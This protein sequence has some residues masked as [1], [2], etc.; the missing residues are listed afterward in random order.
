MGTTA[1]KLAKLVQ[2]KTEI[3][4]AIINKG[5][6]IPDSAT[7]ASYA[8]YIG[9]IQGGTSPTGNIEISQQTGTDVSNYKTASVVSG[10]ASIST[11]SLIINPNISISNTGLITANYSEN[12]SVTTSITTPGWISNDITDNITL[13]GSST[14]QLDTIASNV[15]IPNTVDQII[16]SGQYI[17]GDQ[18]ISGDVN[19]ISD[20]IRSTVSIFGVQ[21]GLV[22]NKYYT[23]ETTPSDDLGIDGDI[24]IQY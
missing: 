24:Y 14:K 17:V 4:T 1:Q 23:G 18:T 16:N 8:E 9:E 15:Y 2:T 22:V 5:V 21:G 12:K 6:S 20:N 11:T 13:S 19:L 3:K 10:Q 7:F